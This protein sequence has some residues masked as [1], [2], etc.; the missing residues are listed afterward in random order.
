MYLSMHNKIENEIKELIEQK[1]RL[2]TDDIGDKARILFELAGSL[3][4]SYFRA[5]LEGK[6]YIIKKLMFELF[7]DSKK[8]LAIG[9]SPLF[10]SS[11]VLNISFGIPEKLDIRTLKEYLSSVDLEGLKDFRKFIKKVLVDE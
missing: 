8:S 9:K 11:E 2:K 1:K 4:Q 5:N 6:I 10:L 3:Y 7:V